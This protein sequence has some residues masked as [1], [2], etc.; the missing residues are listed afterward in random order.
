MD[1]QGSYGLRPWLPWSERWYYGDAVAIVDPFFWLVPLVALGW[2]GRRHW[3]PLALVGGGGRADHGCGPPRRPSRL[4][5]QGGVRR[6][7]RGRGPRLDAPLVR[8]GRA[9]PR[10]RD[11][12]GRARRLRARPGNRQPPRQGR[13]AAG[14]DRAV[15]SRSAVGGPHR[16]GAAVLVG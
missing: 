16:R 10:G 4:L 13:R 11:G 6:A 15:R 2:G 3:R 9:A 1:W 12:A 8:G 14:R 5:A 7:V